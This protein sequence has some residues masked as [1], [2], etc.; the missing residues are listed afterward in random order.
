MNSFFIY[1]IFFVL[2]ALTSILVIYMHNCSKKLKNAQKR[3]IE[4]GEIIKEE[5]RRVRTSISI[6]QQIS[7]D[8]ERKKVLTNR[9]IFLLSF[10]ILKDILNLKKNMWQ[11]SFSIL[12]IIFKIINGSKIICA[13]S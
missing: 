8:D 6:L 12:K 4:E 9:Q 2:I 13:K 5:I 1:L 7:C 10:E 11:R 3:A